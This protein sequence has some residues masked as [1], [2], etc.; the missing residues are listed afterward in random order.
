[1]QTKSERTRAR[2][3]QAARD[4]YQLKGYR[5]TSIDDVCNHIGATKGSFYYHFS[6]KIQALY[7]LLQSDIEKELLLVKAEEPCLN[8]LLCFSCQLLA[9]PEILTALLD[10]EDGPVFRH[11]AHRLFFDTVFPKIKDYIASLKE[12]GEAFYLDEKLPDLVFGGF[13]SGM[14]DLID[15]G[16]QARDDEKRLLSVCTLFIK[17]TRRLFE[18]AFHLSYGSVHIM[19]AKALSQ[20][21]LNA[22]KTP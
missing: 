11:M 9:K 2:L 16:Y 19:D 15:E 21:L 1:M 8:K 12:Q 14:I 18:E 5:N 7:A 13:L 4:L 22:L 10:S 6:S 20:L 17:A 3:L